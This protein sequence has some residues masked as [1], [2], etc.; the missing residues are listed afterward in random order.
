M[1][2][3]SHLEVKHIVA[4][5]MRL[6]CTLISRVLQFQQ[7]KDHIQ[8][9]TL[10]TADERTALR[11]PKFDSRR[12]VIDRCDSVN[13]GYKVLC[14]VRMMDPTLGVPSCAMLYHECDG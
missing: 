12:R 3:I 13:C 1:L 6:D 7:R 14:C 4:P 9:H 11:T 2:R 8:T 10:I 5:L